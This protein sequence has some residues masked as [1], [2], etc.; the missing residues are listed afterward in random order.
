MIQGDIHIATVYFV[1]PHEPAPSLH[2]P[3]LGAK[4][5]R[6]E[7]SRDEEVQ[8]RCRPKR[9]RVG[10]VYEEDSLQ[11][12]NSLR[13]SRSLVP[14]SKR[15][16][17]EDFEE[18]DC[19]LRKACRSEANNRE[20]FPEKGSNLQDSATAIISASASDQAHSSH[21]DSIRK[22]IAVFCNTLQ[23]RSIPRSVC[24]ALG[25]EQPDGLS[26]RGSGDSFASAPFHNAVSG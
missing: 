3:L 7:S 12:H 13:R 5:G 9:R 2:V 15:S 21:N 14:L 11:Q 6:D 10:E 23:A 22:A 18:D 26:D 17:E 16:R 24:N 1:C 19:E 25:L 8:R 4:R 20:G